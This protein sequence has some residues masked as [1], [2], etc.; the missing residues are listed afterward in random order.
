M[1]S[2]P[3][4]QGGGLIVFQREHKTV[5]KF[6]HGALC[7]QGQPMLS[8]LALTVRVDDVRLRGP[9]FGTFGQF[10]AGHRRPRSRRTEFKGRSQLAPIGSIERYSTPHL[11]SHVVDVVDDCSVGIDVQSVFKFTVH[12][13]SYRARGWHAEQK[14]HRSPDNLGCSMGLLGL[15]LPTLFH[16]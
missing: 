15:P 1:H 9:F 7:P 2:D 8:G 3:S 12:H 5:H 14:L 6:T 10:I 4:F 16:M 11:L 13:H